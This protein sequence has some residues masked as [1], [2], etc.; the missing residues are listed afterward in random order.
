MMKKISE[1]FARRSTMQLLLAVLVF[2]S[3]TIIGDRF[4][5]GA[6]VDLTAEGLYSLSDGTKELLSTYDEPIVLNFYF[7]KTLATP[8]PQLLAYGK[9]VEDLLRAFQSVN[10]SSIQLSIIDPEAFSEEEDDAVALGLRGIPLNDGSTLYMGLSAADSVDGEAIIPFFAEEREKFLEYDLVKLLAT[11]DT[12]NRR[13]L[14]LLTTLPMQF[15]PGGPQ[16][17][18]AGQAQP[19][20]LYEQLF[21]FFEVQDLAPDFTEISADTDVLMVVHPP[22]L[23]EDQLFAI[24]QYVLKGGR[25][26][27]FL[28]PHSEAMNPRATVASSSSLGPLLGA[29]GVEMPEGQV[30]G[31]ASL[32]QRVQMGGFGPDAVKDYVFWL[33][34]SDGFLSSADVVTGAIGSLNFASAGVIRPVAEATTRLEPLVTTSAASMLFPADRA[35]GIPDPDSL[36]R[37]MVPTGESYVLSTRIQG[38]AETAF[39]ERVAQAVI[40]DAAEATTGPVASGDINIVLTADTDLFDD[41]FWVQLQDMLGQRIAVPL[42]GNGSF[43]LNLADHISGSEALLSLRGRGISKRPFDKV[44]TLRREAEA[45]YLVEEE[46]LQNRLSETEARIAALE[47]QN[48]DGST[49]LS[50]EQEAE[51]EQFRAQLLETRKALREV[52]RNLRQDIDT[53]GD[54]LAFINIALVP[55][56]IVF[57]VLVRLML[58]RSKRKHRF[59]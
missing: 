43:V 11:L 3:V 34:I 57:Y 20:V 5:R 12:S 24:D 14:S 55:L 8:F 27:F 28:D 10:P 45:K 15:G 48:P 6:R 51:I 32:A 2:L 9:R 49:V 41:R 53:L 35:V 16:A 4:F 22:E 44:D 1:F 36:L 26:L 7:S 42:A 46:E 30:V 21:D 47:S 23:T 38:A 52:K 31:D 59:L 29:W 17:M 13:T 19:Y 58:R 50:V 37:D 18:M 56:L 40:A 33:A 25:A 54:W 39:P